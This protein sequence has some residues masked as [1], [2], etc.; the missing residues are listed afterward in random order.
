MFLTYFATMSV[1]LLFFVDDKELP[2]WKEE[3]TLHKKMQFSIKNLFSKCDQILNGK[4]HF[5]R[6]EGTH[7]VILLHQTAKILKFF[8]SD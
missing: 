4:L 6:I 5:L 8:S 1:L 3:E 2:S 7:R